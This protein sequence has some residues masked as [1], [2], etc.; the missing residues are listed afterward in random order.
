MEFGVRRLDSTP[1]SITSLLSQSSHCFRTIGMSMGSFPGSIK[2]C[3][4]SHLRLNLRFSSLEREKWRKDCG[5][6]SSSGWYRDGVLDFQSP[7]RWYWL[8][9]GGLAVLGRMSVQSP[10]GSQQKE[11]GGVGEGSHTYM[12]YSLTL[13]NLAPN[14]PSL[15]YSSLSLLA[16]EELAL[17]GT[18]L[19]N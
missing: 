6:L 3:S 13:C 14:L 16:S 18:P 19:L 11:D 9:K 2:I 1:T 4:K 10:R 5:F 17:L 7:S 8:G 12:L 15:R